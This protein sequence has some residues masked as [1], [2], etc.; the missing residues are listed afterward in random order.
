MRADLGSIYNEYL[1]IASAAVT[2]G[3][4]AAALYCLKQALRAAN[5]CLD[6]KQ[7]RAKVMRAMNYVR[8]L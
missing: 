5:A 7:Y 6:H 4:K 2:R 3:D 8:A 1:H